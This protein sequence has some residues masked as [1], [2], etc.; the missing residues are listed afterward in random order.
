[1]IT[2]LL[3]ESANQDTVLSADAVRI[4]MLRSITGPYT[5]H[6]ESLDLKDFNTKNDANISACLSLQLVYQ[7]KVLQ[8]AV[9]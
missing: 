8:K 7:Q 5:S 3:P 6:Y 2:V 1:M 9:G 4:H